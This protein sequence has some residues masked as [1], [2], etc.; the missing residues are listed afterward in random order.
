MEKLNARIPPQDLEAERSVLGAILID[1]EAIYKIAE[2]IGPG[3]FYNSNH[4]AIFDSILTLYEQGIPIDVITLS[5]DLKKRKKLKTAGGNEYLTDL[6]GMIPT[7]A[8]IE[9]YASIVRENSIRRKMISIGAEI[10]TRGFDT[11]KDVG[12]LLDECEKNLFSISQDNFK[13]DFVHVKDLLIEA[14]ERIAKY[15]G[16]Q[17]MRGIPSGF[18]YLDSITGGFHNSDLIIVAARPGVGKTSFMLD[19]V[20]NMGIK[21]Q[22][23]IGVFSLEMP[24]DQLIDRLVAIEGNINLFN[25]RMGRMNNSE[26]EMW[27][28][29]SSSLSE[30]SIYIDDTPGQHILDIRTKARR[31]QMEYGL[32][33][34]VIDYLQLLRGHNTENR[35]QE[36]SEISKGLKNLARELKIPLIT[37]SQLSRSIE[38][39]GTKRIPQLSDLRESGSIEQDADIVMF[40]D[41]EEMYNPDS[42]RKGIGDLIIAKHRNGPTGQLELKWLKD[43]AHYANLDRIDVG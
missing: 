16:K 8:N 25:I 23:K 12:D 28:K 3:D 33:V 11:I 37:A 10:S 27:F 24:S 36:V 35:T 30:A 18:K 17:E 26:K 31:M 9:H 39:R 38:Q 21:A 4:S 6:V 1:K 43:G 5:A 22:K 20:C 14:Y 42:D 40:L 2:L 34:L 41:R 13:Q 7:S 19:L 29:A 32:D 15:D